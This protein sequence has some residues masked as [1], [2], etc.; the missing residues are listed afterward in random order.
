MFQ[1]FREEHVQFRATVRG[2]VEREI[3]PYTEQWEKDR[4]FPNEVFKK[5][6]DLGILGAHFD[7]SQ[8][9]GGG[10][11]WFSVVKAEELPRGGS[12]GVSMGLLVQS[13]MATPVIADLGTPEQIDEFLKP[14]LRGEKIA[15]LGVSEPGAGSD[16]AGI[17]TVARADGDDFVIDGQKTFITNGTRA[18]FVTLLVKTQPDAGA[19]GCSFFLVPTALKGFSVSKKLEKIGNHASDTAELFFDGMRVPRRYMLGEPNQGFMYLM[20]NFQTER[21]IAAVGAA[22]ATKLLLDDAVSYGRE[23]TVFG[24]PL[25]KRE[26]WQHRFVDLYTKVEMLQAFV[27]KCVDHYNEDRYVKKEPI[28]ME[29]VKLISMAKIAAGD[30]A[31]EVADACLQFHG[32]W[33]YI[34]DFPIARAYRDQRLLRIGGGTSEVLRYY[35]AKLMGF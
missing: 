32:G 28:S 29:T 20:Q 11:Y 12:A 4:L 17:R 18:D 8:G 6:G 7:E 10:D 22:A 25:I 30:L 33:G 23:R 21:L 16:V 9:G 31:S 15:A 24:K 5:A 27:Y 2:F 19:H 26:I 35:L 1:P 3:R 14:A 13:D 34:E